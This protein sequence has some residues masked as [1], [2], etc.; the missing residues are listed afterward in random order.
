MSEYIS[1]DTLEIFIQINIFR[2]PDFTFEVYILIFVR[3]FQKVQL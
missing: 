3:F 2:T 1:T